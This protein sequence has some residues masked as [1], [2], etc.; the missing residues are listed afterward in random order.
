MSMEID[1]NDL[2][3]E[4]L[5]NKDLENPNEINNDSKNELQEDLDDIDDDEYYCEED[6]LD[7]VKDE[8][9][10]QIKERGKEYYNSGNIIKCCKN[11]HSYYAKVRGTS[12]TPYT[13]LIDNTEYG[14]EMN[15]DCP[16]TY[17]CKHEYAV[18][19]AITNG[20]Y[21]NIELKPEIKEKKNNLQALIEQIPANEIKEYLLSSKG[22][23]YVSFEMEHFEDY[24]RKYLPKQEY[25]FYY[26]NLYNNLVLNQD[27]KNYTDSYINKAKQYIDNNDFIEGYKILKSVIEAYNDS[28]KLNFEDCIVDSLPKIGMFLRVI[29]RKCDAKTKEAV[30]QW[31]TSLNNNNYYNNYYLED[32]I[33]SIN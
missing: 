3:N 33:V 26:N 29:Y 5:N 28:N 16:C 20:E 32:I 8:F 25:E 19:L 7:E 1:T 14:I 11:S 13:V 10:Y 9:S 17:A 15:C 12:T 24:F 21:E 27:I 31:I 18:L 30:E 2:L 23:D 22:I 4:V 6:I